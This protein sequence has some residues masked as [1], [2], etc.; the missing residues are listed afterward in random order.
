MNYETFEKQFTEATEE[1][2]STPEAHR[3]LDL[4]RDLASAWDDPQEHI[5]KVT[6]DELLD[7]AENFDTTVAAYERNIEKQNLMLD[8]VM[9]LKPIRKRRL[10]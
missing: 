3:R 4:F 6:L 10:L 1:R 9:Q 5:D 2:D 8:A 7:L